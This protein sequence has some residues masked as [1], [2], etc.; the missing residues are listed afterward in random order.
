MPLCNTPTWI[1]VGWNFEQYNLAKWF[2]MNEFVFKETLQTPQVSWNSGL[3][4]ASP[5][6]RNLTM[7]I[8]P[9]YKETQGSLWRGCLEPERE[10]ESLRKRE[11]EGP[12]KRERERNAQPTMLSCC[13]HPSWGVRPL[14]EDSIL[15][16]WSCSSASAAIW[17]QSLKRSQDSAEPQLTHRTEGDKKTLNHWFG[18]RLLICNR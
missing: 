4:E 11:R 10:R 13:C 9:C 14:D 12:R 16:I 2:W 15:E 7:M 3:G 6:V 17:L 8:A 18:G 5:S 1:W